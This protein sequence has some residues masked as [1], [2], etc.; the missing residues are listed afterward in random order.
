[1]SPSFRSVGVPFTLRSSW[2]IR[3][4]PRLRG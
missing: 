2:T 3:T 4:V 1:M